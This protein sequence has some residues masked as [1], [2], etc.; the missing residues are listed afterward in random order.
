[1]G[2]SWLPSDPTGTTLGRPRLAWWYSYITFT[3]KKR[4]TSAL[5]E[6]LRVRFLK[7]NHTYIPILSFQE[8]LADWERGYGS[9]Q[10]PTPIAGAQARKWGARA[11]HTQ[12]T[13]ADNTAPASTNSTD[14]CKLLVVSSD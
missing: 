3:Q 8:S 4:F 11:A 9:L 10:A 14:A 5:N 12:D 6:S 1:M 7:G 2:L 13:A